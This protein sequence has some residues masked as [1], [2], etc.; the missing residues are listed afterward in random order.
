MQERR[1]INH[2]STAEM[3]QNLD[4]LMQQKR[5]RTTVAVRRG[6]IEV[7][8]NI[9]LEYDTEARTPLRDEFK[10]IQQRDPLRAHNMYKLIRV[11]GGNTKDSHGNKFLASDV[12][13]ILGVPIALR[14]HTPSAKKRG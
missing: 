5:I 12:Q 6:C 10:A 4:Q 2:G 13:M 3:L 1:I 8:R 14:I 9:L 11:V 7:A